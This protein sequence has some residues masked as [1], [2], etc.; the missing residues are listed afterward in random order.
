MSEGLSDTFLHILLQSRHY[1]RS[2]SVTL[3]PLVPLSA[4]R[5][6]SA[7]PQ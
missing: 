4:A 7:V 3:K 1:R 2:S 6:A 5:T